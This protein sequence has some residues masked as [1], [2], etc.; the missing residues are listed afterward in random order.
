MKEQQTIVATIKENS[1]QI[2]NKIDSLLKT[3]N[4][5]FAGRF[6][7]ENNGHCIKSVFQMNITDIPQP[8]VKFSHILRYENGNYIA[9]YQIEGTKINH[10]YYKGPSADIKSLSEAIFLQS[11]E[12]AANLLATYRNKFENH[13]F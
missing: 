2:I 13:P 4:F 10:Q 1:N 7:I 3:N 5:A 12:I 11:R 8:Q 9:T 6:H